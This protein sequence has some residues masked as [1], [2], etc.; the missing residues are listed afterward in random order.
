M[1][2]VVVMLGLVFVS[3]SC[4][5][6]GFLVEALSQLLTKHPGPGLESSVSGAAIAQGKA[7]LCSGYGSWVSL[8]DWEV[9]PGNHESRV[10]CPALFCRYPKSL[11]QYHREHERERLRIIPLYLLILPHSPLPL[12]VSFS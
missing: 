7:V 10:V 1:M 8:A 12:Q 11:T 5:S 2:E 6:T 4:G 9:L 3:S